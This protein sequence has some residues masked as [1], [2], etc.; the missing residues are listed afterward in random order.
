MHLTP[1][2]LNTN[3]NANLLIDRDTIF[4]PVTLMDF[5]IES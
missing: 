4:I 5:S 3:L 2:E 1:F